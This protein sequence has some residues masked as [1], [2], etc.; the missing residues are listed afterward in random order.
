MRP[1][2]R[3][4]P[5]AAIVQPGR[6][7]SREATAGTAGVIV[8]AADYFHAVYWAAERAQR[9]LLLSGWEFDSALPL[10]RGDDRPPGA[11]V[12]LVR[13]LDGLCERNPNLYICILAWNFHVVL[14]AEREWLQ[15]MYFHWLTHEHLHFV[16]EDSPVSGGSMHQKFAVID[17]RIAFLG[18]MGLREACWDDRRHLAENPDRLTRGR[19]DKPYH[20]VQAYLAGGEAPM[21][22][23]QYFFQRWQ[24]AGGTLPPLPPPVPGGDDYRPLGA[25]VLGGGPVALSRT[26]PHTTGL[27]VR[28]VERLFAGAIAAAEQLIFIET[29]YF[30]SR[31]VRDALVRRMREPPRSK[32]DIVVVNERGEAVKEDIAVGLRQ[33]ENVVELRRVAGET[34]HAFG[35]YDSLPDG[36]GDDA[37]RPTYIHSKLMVVDD[38]F[39]TVGSANVT[40]RSMG[41]DCELHA[42]W[43]ATPRDAAL[44]RRIR[45]VRVSLL[46]EHSGV[47]GAH[48]VRGLLPA[49]GLVARLDAMAAVSGA[50]FRRHRPPSPAQRAMLAVVEPES[51]PFDSD[52]RDHA[53]LMDPTDERGPQTVLA[54][55]VASLWSALTGSRRRAA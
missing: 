18:G 25:L 3:P 19:P 27:I 46:A 49:E 10:L 55:A 32:L 45:R 54:R 21:A 41:V 40:N 36:A 50:R 8:D 11:E 31:T 34:G 52:G 6:N 15:R 37:S 9:S 39:L 20:D 16:L 2:P 33:L 23:E 44:H 48:A 17:G 30:S 28:D 47:S 26:Q 5:A 1:R 43:E 53:A 38:R 12:R 4:D 24:R 22:V 42:S 51:L 35:V 13:F 7:A 29:Q 14:A